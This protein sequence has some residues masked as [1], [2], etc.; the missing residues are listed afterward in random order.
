MRHTGYLSLFPS[1]ASLLF[2]LSG[3]ATAAP[4]PPFPPALD[5][6][7]LTTMQ[8]NGYPGLSA[9]VVRKGRVLWEGQYGY[10]LLEPPTP[11]DG[12]T[13]FMLAS[14]AKTVTGA[15][16]LQLYEQGRIGL[17]D[18][19]GSY[20]GFPVRNPQYPEV[21]ITVRMLLNHTSGIR[22]TPG[23]LYGERLYSDGDSPIP[24]DLFLEGYLT[25]GT[26]HGDSYANFAPGTGYLYSNYAVALAGLLVERISGVPF[27]QYCQEHIFEPLGM[28]DTSWFL[29]GLDP[30]RIAMPYSCGG[31]G[32]DKPEQTCQAQGYYGYPD[33]PDGQ[34]RT[35]ARQLASFLMAM[36]GGGAYRG[37]R[38]LESSTVDTIFRPN[39]LSGPGEVQGLVWY[40]QTF[41]SDLIWGHS[42]GDRGV[43]TSM[44]FRPSD[45]TGV[46][47]LA[48]G[49]SLTGLD[50][51]QA[52]LFREA[53]KR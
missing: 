26:Y 10:A 9:L 22:D 30:A 27:E 2:A 41:D 28:H 38:I 16:L 8:Q 35:G 29:A 18:D 3:P 32:A 31:A 43:N 7:I 53:A 21:P 1:I 6:W 46:I 37:A 17:D 51:L 34:L 42:G 24:L 15:A 23:R 20:A 49:W 4:P 45:G 39:P 13:L 47:L 44:F 50:T 25:G 5:G 52:R 12:R 33:F 40:A 19:V 36:M 11:V 14:T 48:N